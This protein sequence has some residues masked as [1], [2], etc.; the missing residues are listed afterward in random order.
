MDYEVALNDTLT[1]GD[2]GAVLN[3]TAG[4]LSLGTLLF[5]DGI[6]GYGAI[7][8][9]HLGNYSGTGSSWTLTDNKMERWQPVTI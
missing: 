8:S 2:N 3:G 4:T 5:M 9:I 6:N 1:L 7:G